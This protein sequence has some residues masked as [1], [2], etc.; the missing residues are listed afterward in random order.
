MK[1]CVS[2]LKLVNVLENHNPNIIYKRVVKSLNQMRLDV[3]IEILTFRKQQKLIFI[4]R[5]YV[6]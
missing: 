3:T 2:Y 5:K 4:R 1:I 6:S